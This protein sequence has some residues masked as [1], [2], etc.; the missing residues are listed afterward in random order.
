MSVAAPTHATAAIPAR[1]NLVLLAVSTMAAAGCLYLASNGGSLTLKVFAAVAFSF[2]NNTIFSLMHEA[3]HGIFHSNPVVND[4]AGRICAAFFPTS[5][6][7][8]RV[9]HLSHH[10]NNRGDRER[11]DYYGPQENRFLKV[12]QWYCI[13]TGPYWI[14]APL[15]CLIYGVTVGLVPWT[16]LLAPGS[17]FGQQ[18]SAEPFLDSL[19]SV[20]PMAARL[21]VASSIAIQAA[22]I[23]LLDLSLVG[24]IMCYACFA[25]N[26]GARCNMPITF[27]PA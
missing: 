24:W 5:F 7:L 6:S 9:F 2:V 16:R 10:R 23:Y 12:V 3:V 26:F 1:L 21:D 27:F 20:S 13:L 19:R 18:T 22:M 17:R 25:V 15:F 8:Q 11:F 4:A 14:S